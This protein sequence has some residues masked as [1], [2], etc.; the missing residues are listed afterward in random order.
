MSR[1]K[2]N[3]IRALA[4]IFLLVIFI[5]AFTY[6]RFFIVMIFVCAAVVDLIR[7]KLWGVA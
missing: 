7:K 2:I 6:L 1:I 5:F 4:I 3:I